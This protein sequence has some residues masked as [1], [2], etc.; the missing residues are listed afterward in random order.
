[1]TDYTQAICA[2]PESIIVNCSKLDDTCIRELFQHGLFDHHYGG[3]CS[4]KLKCTHTF[5]ELFMSMRSD[6]TIWGYLTNEH[7]LGW[8]AFLRSVSNQNPQCPQIEVRFR[9]PMLK[10]TFAFTYVRASDKMALIN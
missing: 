3:R 2:Y 10:S 9:V 6:V 8:C 1:M 4:P 7:I 5:N